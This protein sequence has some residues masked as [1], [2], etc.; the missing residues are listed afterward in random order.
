[1][2]SDWIPLGR[3]IDGLGTRTS[4]AERHRL[5][6]AIAASIDKVARRNAGRPAIAYPPELP[7]SEA[8]DRIAAAIRE[9]QVVIV[10]GETGSGKTTQIPKIC[11]ELGRGTRG[12]IGHTQPRRIAARSVA[13][14]IAE[15][16]NAELGTVVG[17]KVRFT[18]HTRPDAYIKLMTDG[19]L[20]AETQSDRALAAYDTIIIDEAHERSLN[21]DFLLGYLKQLLPQRPDLKLIV[22]CAIARSAAARPTRPTTRKSS[23]KRSSPRWRT[24][25]AKA[26]ATSWCSSRASARSARRP[27]CWRKAWPGG[28]TPTRLR[29]CRCLPACPPSSSSV[30]SAAAG[31]DAS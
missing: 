19:I 26:R 8:R 11:L 3:R 22:K 28:R 2:A 13:A 15:E 30:S 23:R 17:Y 9:H 24:S 18:D 7:V 14:R 1:M 27:T 21:I 4:A 5:E 29:S 16:L 12:L 6:Q 10:C 25:G 20:L 31:G